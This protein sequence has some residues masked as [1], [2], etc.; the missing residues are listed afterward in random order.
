MPSLVTTLKRSCSSNQINVIIYR[1]WLDKFQQ[2]LATAVYSY[3]RLIIDH[4]AAP[5]HALRQKEVDFC[6]AALRERV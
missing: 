1:P 2:L 5:Y 6:V 4:Q 3:L